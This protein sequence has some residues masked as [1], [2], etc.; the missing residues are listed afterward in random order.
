MLS[1]SILQFSWAKPDK[2]KHLKNLAKGLGMDYWHHTIHRNPHPLMGT[3]WTVQEGRKM[4]RK[5]IKEEGINILMPRSTMPALMVNK[6]GW[7]LKR[8]EVKV[9]FDADGLPLE[10]RLDFT[11]LKASDFQY[12]YLK[13]QETKMLKKADKILCRTQKSIDYHIPK[14]GES[15]RKD[16]HLVSNGRDKELFSFS[17][18]S[19]KSIRMDLGIKEEDKLWIYTGSLG[20]QYALKDMM[21]IFALYLEK[22]PASRFLVLSSNGTY[23]KQHLPKNLKGKVI[24]RSVSFKEIPAYLSA[25]DIAFSLRLPAWSMRGVAPIKLGEYLLMGLPVVASNGVGDTELLFQGLPFVYLYYHADK[26]RQEKVVEWFDQ[27]PSVN[28][29]EIRGFALE[30]FSLEKSIESYNKALSGII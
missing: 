13:R 4:I 26:A 18:E 9:V 30:H 25:A 12:K 24:H 2:V 11:S 5:I 19:R 7:F 14:V 1:C 3:W 23:L 22:Y 10:E 21:G 27:L 20:P 6:L 29:Q 15:R 28:P 8:K 16:F 17:E